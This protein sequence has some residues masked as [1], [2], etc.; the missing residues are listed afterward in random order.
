V[1]IP[2]QGEIWWAEIETLRRPVVVVT[3]SEAVSVLTSI[4]VAPVTRTI[5]EIPT[6][7]RLGDDEGLGE[8]CV[9]SF[10]NLQRIHRAALTTKIGDLGTRRSEICTAVQSMTDC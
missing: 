4:V 8:E 9:A 2:R 5:R 7:I 10:D 1:S 6:E 3:R